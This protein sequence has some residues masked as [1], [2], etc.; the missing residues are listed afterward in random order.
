MPIFKPQSQDRLKELFKRAKD[1]GVVAVGIDLDGC[2]ST[3][4]AYR[5]KPV[6]RKSP[7]E[8]IEIVKFTD[9]PVIFKGI[10]NIKDAQHVV[11]SGAYAIIIS[12]HGGR[13][14]DSSRGVADVL[15]EIA[16][17]FKGKILIGADGAV[18]TGYDVIKLLA[19]GADFVSIGRPL[20]RMAIAGGPWAVKDYL[21]Y[22]KKDFRNAMLMTGCDNLS[23]INKDILI[24]E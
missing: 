12:N 9:L 13:V 15:P 14:L 21:D 22:V 11:N 18:R 23:E 6:Y 8:L 5:N 2:G 3:N 17:K 7:Q 19:L 10:M 24:K 4:W 1:A 20:I 16:D